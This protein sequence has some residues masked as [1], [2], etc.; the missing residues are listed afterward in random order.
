LADKLA[1]LPPRLQRGE[2]KA[3]HAAGVV[4]GEQVIF[5]SLPFSRRAQKKRGNLRCP[6][7]ALDSCLPYLNMITVPA[8]RSVAQWQRGRGLSL[9]NPGAAWPPAGCD[10]RVSFCLFL[11]GLEAWL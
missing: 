5:R 1:F 11:G 9:R 2:H 7:L 4:A 10:S 6:A 3:C 8:A